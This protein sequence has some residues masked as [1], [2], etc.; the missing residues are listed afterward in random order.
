VIPITIPDPTLSAGAVTL[1]PD[2]VVIP[3]SI[4]TPTVSGT[5]TTEEFTPWGVIERIIDASEY[6]SGTV[7]FL[8]VGM[9][10]SA[11]EAPVKA[12]LFS[13]TD[14][15]VVPGSEIST[16]STSYVVVRSGTFDL[17]ALYG[18]GQKTYR[19]EFGGQTG[20]TFRFHGG[21]VK[22]ILS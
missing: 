11:A 13:I 9:F 1:T 6:A 17:L 10:T 19:L 15:M 5:G 21:D 16:T 2:P 3:I 22:P 20:G 18:S 7:F 12:R 4:P 8:E 14:G